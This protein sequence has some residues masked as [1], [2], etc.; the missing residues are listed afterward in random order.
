MITNW[1]LYGVRQQIFDADS[2]DT[3]TDVMREV[4]H[5]VANKQDKVMTVQFYRHPNE[6]DHDRWLAQVEY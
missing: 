6:F 3:L 1:D 2:E 5:W 4:A